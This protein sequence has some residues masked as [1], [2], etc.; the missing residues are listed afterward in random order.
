MLR[1][2]D[3]QCKVCGKVQERIVSG[4]EVI[5]SLCCKAE[6]DRL[7]PRVNVCMGPVGA[8]GY[9][10][11]TLGTYVSTNRQR[12]ELCREQGVTPKGETPKPQGDAW[13]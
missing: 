4:D 5:H 1:I 13:V 8:H 3:F 9:Y 2:F 12:R 11:E 7:P 6:C 10:D